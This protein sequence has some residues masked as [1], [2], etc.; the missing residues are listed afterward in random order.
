MK[1]RMLI[2]LSALMVLAVPAARADTGKNLQRM[3]HDSMEHANEAVH[4][5]HGGSGSGE[6]EPADD[7]GADDPADGPADD[8]ADDSGSH[9]GGTHT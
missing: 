4:G 2:A 8:G 9:S 6:V 5:Q 7:T 3:V 1:R